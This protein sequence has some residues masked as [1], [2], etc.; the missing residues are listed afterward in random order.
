[1]RKHDLGFGAA[2]IFN[3]PASLL[4]LAFLPLLFSAPAQAS[5]S[6]VLHGHVPAA[7]MALRPVGSLPATNRLNLAIGLP[8]RNQETLTNL[9]QQLY[10]PASPNYRQYL[11]PE[12]FTER[13][14][15]AE[16][17]YQ[18]V[19]AFAQSNGFSVT[20]AH[21]NRMLVDVNASAA[22]I[23][24]ALHVTLGVYQH[25]TEARAFFA[26][27]N[28]PSLDLPV[29]VL[30]ISGLDN[31]VLPRPCLA[32]TPLDAATGA[33]PQTGSGP[34]GL[35]IGKDFRAAYAPG[36]SLT[37]S[38][39]SVGLFELDGYYAPD[40]AAYQSQAGLPGVTLTNVL[41]NG[42]D[43]TPGSG[44]IEV[45]LDID[46]ASA[47]A[48]GLA[49]VIVYEGLV[50]DDVLNR[51]AT[52]NLAKQLS[53][54]WGWSPLDATAVQIFQQFAAQGQSMFQASGDTDAYPGAVM[55]PADDPYITIV[56][57]TTLT[58]SNGAWVSETVWNW[59]GGVGSS[60]G[61]STRYA[62]PSWQQGIDMSTNQ[63]STTMRNIPDVA[64]TADNVFVVADNGTQYRVGGTSCAA[65]LW[66]GFMGMVNQLALAGGEPVA[67]FINPAVYA[68]G[69]RAGYTSSLHDIA[70]GNN[71]SAVSP[72]KY[73]AVPG[74]DLC[75][76]WGTPTGSDLIY[77][78]GFPEPL[79][80]SPTTDAL[81]TGPVGGPF[82]PAPQSYLLTNQGSGALDWTLAGG[83]PWL[84]VTPTNGTLAAGGPAA[85]VTVSLATSAS[86]LPPGTYTATLSFTN[87][88]NHFGQS[89]SIRLAI[90][91]PPMITSQPASQAVLEGMNATF[92][93]GTAA[94]ALS[95][96]QW[97]QDNG[98][99]VTNLSDGSGISGSATSTLTISNVAPTNVGAYSVVI[100]NA[101]GVAT[102]SNAFLTIIPW[103]PVIV[104]QP[105]NTMA[106][107][108]GPAT[109]R[110]SVVGTPPF[111]NQWQMNGTNLTNDANF[112][113][114]TFRTMTVRNASPAL[115][116]T[117]SVVV[118]NALGSVTS[119]GATFSLI[120]VT[121]PGVTMTT[122]HSFSGF[123]GLYPYA[124]L[125]E[126]R[127]GN[128]YGTTLSGGNYYSGT[129]FQMT[130][131]GAVTVGHSF[132]GFSDGEGPYAGLAQGTNGLF[133]GL[134]SE[135]GTYGGGVVFQTDTNGGFYV[136]NSFNSTNGAFP[137][138]GLALGRDGSLYGTTLEG[139]TNGLGAVFKLAPNNAII[140]L[141]SFSKTIGAFPSGVL[142][143][144]SDGSFYGT[145]ENGGTNG[146]WGTIFRMTP[147]GALV[148]LH[149]FGNS[150]GAV[151][152]PGLVQDTDGAF[153]GTTYQG[154]SK[155]AG[156]VFKITPEGVFTNLYSFSGGADGGNPFGGLL[157]SS[158]GNLYGTTEGGGDYGDGT[159]FRITSKGDLATL[160]QLDGY[161]G[162]S[163]EAALVQGIDGGLYG[164]TSAGGAYSGGAIFRVGIDSALQITRQPETRMAFLG[165]NVTF[166]VATFGATPVSYQWRKNGRAI[167][168]GENLSGS[169]ARTLTLTNI[170]TSD[171]G[172]YSV[173]VSNASGSVTS[174]N[175]LLQIIVSPPY[176]ASDP[177]DQTV[178]V[179]ATATFEV[180]AFGDMPLFFQWQ[181]NGTN[182]TNSGTISGSATSALTVSSATAADQ[183]TYSVVVSNALEEVASLGAVLTVVPTV[184]PGLGLE[185]IY[186]FNGGDGLNPYAGLAQGKD[187]CLYGTTYAGGAAGFGTTYRIT[188]NGAFTSMYSFTNGTDGAYLYAGLTQGADGDFYGAAFQGGIGSFG[189]AFRMAATGA[190]TTLDWFTGG[191]DGSYPAAT[192]VQGID[193]SFYSDAYQGGLYDYGT[194]FKIATNGAVTPLISF[195]STNG[196][197]PQA[198][199]VLAADGSFYGTA[200]GG[201]DMGYGTVFRLAANGALTVL[202]SFNYT[203]GAYPACGL[204]L[205]GDGNL[206]GTASQGGDYGYGTVFKL[207]TNGA[208]ATLVSF[209]LTN[210]AFP[211]AGLVLAA[212]GSFYGATFDGGVGGAG[213]VFKITTNSALTTL[214]WFDGSNGGN[215]QAPLIQAADG[216]LYGT[217]E[218]GGV[219]YDGTDL[220]GNG[221]VFRL[222]LATAPS[223]TA[224]ISHQGTNLLLRWIGG[225]G[226][227]QVQMATR[228]ANPDWKNIGGLLNTDHLL[229][230]SS[231][232]AA[233]YRIQGR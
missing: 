107:P 11:T 69:K 22:D 78:L 149:S 47:M 15:P 125:L 56:G 68:L 184:A 120:S 105:T 170:G 226:P 178:L 197:F 74:Y 127:D 188:T 104:A 72:S 155:G 113:R 53:S 196:S 181:K 71:Q 161:Q 35:Y 160:V 158:D 87:L 202:V 94:N 162:A 14:G 119:E 133:Y 139:G 112:V 121:A 98:T 167:A 172:T 102:S 154:G 52:D 219:G 198:P 36:V 80:I 136:V 180:E 33:T 211:P 18:A 95:S 229:L 50:P 9:L 164:T 223:I 187:G 199:L 60:G 6:Q 200:Y 129:V 2:G 169:N 214:V 81:F 118:S 83:A 137:F 7:V 163:P 175:A 38:G 20:G 96:F 28:E 99:F 8:L 1:M 41:L 88:N 228:L 185:T 209:G 151:P 140:P 97:R 216:N 77:A 174:A 124:P 221:T 225:S 51:M 64:L 65:P 176:I 159:V 150:D 85:A 37:G 89:R 111:T 66:A 43:G 192:F 100:S 203:N 213:T 27:P 45:A 3:P 201:G 193:G 108:G 59:G 25:P 101:A 30:H 109:F 114:T 10:D 13:F 146:S 92:S 220:S 62:L 191:D 115:Q 24:K 110:V 49:A 144:G 73:S 48:P 142:M 39:Q 212:D 182:L 4:A 222:T 165:E 54:S 189:T 44:N 130:T 208:L 91:T 204:V 135:G 5:A 55:S 205:A 166:S 194:L 82:G 40:I 63:G 157:L 19:I 61:I 128:F 123:D 67:G 116:A 179:G 131:N 186:A 218:Y 76:G 190:M 29:R 106:L 210:G 90:V 122:L 232:A 84:S 17:D 145:A 224:G 143:Q 230:Q 153:Y 171:A 134:I 231:N 93:V 156:T 57:G 148:T 132:T 147:S 227:Y 34:S 117:Y 79:K 26:P 31:Y 141:V 103:R 126:G 173:I 233:F 195:D 75:T 207:T 32:T 168:D 42:F 152:I 16:S 183:G 58:T 215:P 86:N 177:V 206:Y 12:Q 138:A 46:M 217:T 70:T 23:E 21:P